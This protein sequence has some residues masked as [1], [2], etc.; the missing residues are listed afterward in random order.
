VARECD[1]APTVVRVHPRST[2]HTQIGVTPGFVPLGGLGPSRLSLTPDHADA[3]G[4]S[5]VQVMA[6]ARAIR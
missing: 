6:G 1:L 2:A 4:I 3:G 5:T